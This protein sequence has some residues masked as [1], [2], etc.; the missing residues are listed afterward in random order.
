VGGYLLLLIKRLAAVFGRSSVIFKLLLFSDGYLSVAILTIHSFG[1]YYHFVFG[2]YWVKVVI[3]KFFLDESSFLG[4]HLSLELYWRLFRLLNLLSY[5][6]FNDNDDLLFL[7]FEWHRFVNNDDFVNNEDFIVLL[8]QSSLR[9]KILDQ[10]TVGHHSIADERL[11]NPFGTLELREHEPHE[12]TQADIEP[13]GDTVEDKA[14]KRVQE[15]KQTEDDPV[16]E[17]VSV[18]VLIDAL[19]S[20]D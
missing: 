17:P 15:V 18:I 7:L 2:K 16:G 3:I 9:D 4:K 14:G 20:A 11:V 10:L 5:S 12:N 13:V 19:D 1:F 8:S 6:C